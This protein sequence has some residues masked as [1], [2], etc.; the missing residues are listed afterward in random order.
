MILC[1]GQQRVGSLRRAFVDLPSGRHV[2]SIRAENEGQGQVGVRLFRQLR[3]RRESWVTFAPDESAEVRHLQFD[4]GNQS[5]Y[6]QFTADK[7]LRLS[8]TGPTTLRLSTRLDFDHTMNGVQQYSLQTLLNGEPSR[9]FHFD[10]T[11]LTSAAYVER[12]DILPGVRKNLRIPIPR[13]AHTVE[14]R[15]LRPDN[16][17]V[18]TMIHIPMRDVQR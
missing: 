3:R 4:S 6:Y 1:R 10:C 18:A 2:V 15:C 9:A 8:V 11:A 13:G 14:V 7:P 12:P 5:T 16:C 17:S